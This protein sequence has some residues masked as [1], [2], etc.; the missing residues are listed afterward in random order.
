MSD[1]LWPH[2][3]QHARLLCPSLYPG[4]CSNSCPLSWWCYL[5]ISSSVVPFSFCFNLSQHQ[6]LFPMSW[7]FTS[8]GKSIG[9]SALAS[10]LPMNIQDWFPLGLTERSYSS[11]PFL[12]LKINSLHHHHIISFT[13]PSAFSFFAHVCSILRSSNSFSSWLFSFLGDTSILLMALPT[14]NRSHTHLYQKIG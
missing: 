7:V 3:L 2:G 14:P 11:W 4:V 12:W 10:I 1:S 9:A 6:G 8:G 5:T 13:I